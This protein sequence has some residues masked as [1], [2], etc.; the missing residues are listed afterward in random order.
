MLILYDYHHDV[1]IISVYVI[2]D[3]VYVKI[4]NVINNALVDAG[5]Y[6]MYNNQALDDRD[7]F[8]IFT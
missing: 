7:V 3:D 2:F 8:K 5:K 1:N 6:D 4:I